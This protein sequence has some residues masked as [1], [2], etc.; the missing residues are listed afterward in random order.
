A[1]E[2]LIASRER[3]IDEAEE[4]LRSWPERLRRREAELLEREREVLQAPKSVG[5]PG[6]AGRKVGRNERCACGSGLKYK[7]CHGA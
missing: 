3:D 5:E 4:R 7:R 2:S 6:A 1:R